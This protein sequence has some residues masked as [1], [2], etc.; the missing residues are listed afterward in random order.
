[1]AKLYEQIGSKE[2][3]KKEYARFLELWRDA[4]AGIPEFADAKKRLTQWQE[5]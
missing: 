1:L 4:D 3:A 5:R 2:E